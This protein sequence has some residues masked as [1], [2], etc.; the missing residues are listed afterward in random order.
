MGNKHRQSYQ[1]IIPLEMER[2]Y[3][4]PFEISAAQII[5]EH[6]KSNATFIATGISK[7]PDIRIRNV[8]WEIKSPT[9][10]GKRTIQHQFTRAKTQSKNIIFDTRFIKLPAAKVKPA[11]LRELSYHPTITRLAYINKDD[12]VTLLRDK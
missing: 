3:P 5:A 7:T 6:F 8:L 10:K 12:T 11:V 2:N 9:G 4:K 1:V